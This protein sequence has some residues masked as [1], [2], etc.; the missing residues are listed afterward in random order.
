MTREDRN[1]RAYAMRR[2]RFAEQAGPIPSYG[3]REWL[4]LPADD[5]RKAGAVWIAAEC[6]RQEYEPERIAERHLI[7]LDVRR[8]AD[9][10][11]W[12]PV[13]AYVRRLA[14]QPTHDELSRRRAGVAA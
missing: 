12:A 11:D 4:D 2:I 6:W 14:D 9:A 13:A 10:A 5:P 3:S 7:D 1:A 8:D